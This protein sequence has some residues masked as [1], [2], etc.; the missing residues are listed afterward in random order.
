MSNVINMLETLH[1][2]SSRKFRKVNS[3]MNKAF[4]FEERG[5]TEAANHISKLVDIEMEKISKY[6]NFIA[7]QKVQDFNGNFD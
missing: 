1:C 3:L 7:M 6:D 5:L 4:E 2:L